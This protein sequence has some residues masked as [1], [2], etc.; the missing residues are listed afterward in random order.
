MR[1]H[2]SDKE[3]IYLLKAVLRQT[4]DSITGTRKNIC[5]VPEQL[6]KSQ[7]HGQIED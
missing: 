1:K 5:Q 3:L 4:G 2:V 6:N 7:S